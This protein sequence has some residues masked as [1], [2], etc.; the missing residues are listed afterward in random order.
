MT[1][2]IYGPGCARC[3]ETER[4]VRHVIEQAGITADVRKA[5][6]IVEL[7]KAGILA[8]PAIAIDGKVVS[9]GRI[10]SEDEIKGWIAG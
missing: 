2:T 8:T 6:D 4:R 7:A 3:Y 10:P 9:S 1:I 5:S